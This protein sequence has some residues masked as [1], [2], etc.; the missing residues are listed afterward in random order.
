MVPPAVD[1]LLA[2]EEE[3]N[4]LRPEEEAFFFLV[5]FDLAIESSVDTDGGNMH[6]VFDKELWEGER[7]DCTGFVPSRR[8]SSMAL[9]LMTEER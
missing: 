3:P 5:V 8:G 2:E 9:M 6:D 1:L 7:K 4:P